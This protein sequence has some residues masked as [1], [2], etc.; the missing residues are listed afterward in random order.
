MGKDH[1]IAFGA[2]SIQLP[3]RRGKLG[4]AGLKVELSHQLDGQLIVWYGDE[5][6]HSLELPLD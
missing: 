4:Y 3:A 6:L 5:R 1:V 2:R